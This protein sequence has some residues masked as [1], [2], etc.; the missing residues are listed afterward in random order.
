MSVYQTVKTEF[1]AFEMAILFLYDT[2]E[3]REYFD[4]L[5]W[6]TISV[7]RGLSE[8]FMEKFWTYLNHDS[9]SSN[10]KMSV[11]FIYDHLFDLNLKVVFSQGHNK[12]KDDF[13]EN[14]MIPLQVKNKKS[15]KVS[16]SERMRRMK[17]NEKT[18]TT[19]VMFEAIFDFLE[20]EYPAEFE[21]IDWVG[22][23]R[24]KSLSIDFIRKYKHKLN[25][26]NICINQTLSED[27]IKEF[28]GYINL[29]CLSSSFKTPMMS[30]DFVYEKRKYINNDKKLLNNLVFPRSV[31]IHQISLID[32]V[33]IDSKHTPIKQGSY[34]D[35]IIKKINKVCDV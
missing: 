21:N 28:F 26:N 14:V 33:I 4:I 9:I 11:P 32:K 20:K 22:L 7:M 15:K 23:S 34:D 24:Y 35:L 31:F 12:I 5:D 17:A 30:I 13:I 1:T 19:N 18:T 25:W 3:F 2:P 29:R 16:L 8:P 10:Q 6:N 27:N